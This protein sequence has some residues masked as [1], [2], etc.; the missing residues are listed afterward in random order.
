[1]TPTQTAH[2]PARFFSATVR[3]WFVIP[4]TAAAIAAAAYV[5]G[6]AGVGDLV[7]GL[8]WLGLVLAAYCLPAIVAQHRGHHNAAAI[9][10]LDLLLGWTGLGWIIAMVWAMTAPRQ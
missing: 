2:T 4:L 7:R 3:P 10:M 1:M 6:A 9:L 5:A 8:F